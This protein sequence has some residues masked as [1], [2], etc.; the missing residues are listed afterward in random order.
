MDDTKKSIPIKIKQESEEEEVY[1]D[2]FMK[3]SG[4]LVTSV[5]NKKPITNSP[6]ADLKKFNS[7][8]SSANN[9]S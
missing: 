3:S 4:L 7:P 6:A 5:E 1:E 8:I 9:N 2:D